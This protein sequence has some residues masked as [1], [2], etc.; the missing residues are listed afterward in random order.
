M[1]S[2]RVY[3]TSF[4]L[5]QDNIAI[6]PS[7]TR[8]LCEDGGSNPKRLIGLTADGETFTFAENNIV[9]T[10]YEMEI[11]EGVFPG[12]KENFYDVALGSFTSREW[13]GATFWEDWLF[14][15]IQSPGVTFAITG[16]WEEGSL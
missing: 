12:T 16:P 9:L 10:Q 3:A 6:S 8:L 5:I 4:H 7:G 13:A 2:H 14:V 15:N 11:L 1:L